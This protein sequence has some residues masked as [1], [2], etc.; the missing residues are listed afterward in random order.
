MFETILNLSK[1][2]ASSFSKET[3]LL[4]DE[5]DPKKLMVA[6]ALNLS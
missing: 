6:P 1:D 2:Y 4:E 3:A 5:N